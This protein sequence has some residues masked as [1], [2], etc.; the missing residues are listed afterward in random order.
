MNAPF[1]VILYSGDFDR[2]HYGLIAATAAACL[3]REVT[4]FITMAACRAFAGKEAW[5]SL[6]LSS[7][8]ARG[9][10]S[11]QALNAY[12]ASQH[13]ATFEELLEA[14]IALSIRFIVCETG[15]RAEKLSLATL[16]STIPVSAGGMVS[17]LKHASGGE[18]ITF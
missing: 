18:L 17:F 14:A 9:I 13:I 3:D 12:F 4:V 2:I 5:H 6:T 16:A 8:A 7:G 11:A 15:L 10:G 1:S